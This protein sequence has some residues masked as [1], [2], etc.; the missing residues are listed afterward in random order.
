MYVLLYASEARDMV[1]P[2]VEDEVL[3]VHAIVRA[4]ELQEKK[5]RKAFCEAVAVKRRKF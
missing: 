1:N 4:M 5:D 3:R 2:K